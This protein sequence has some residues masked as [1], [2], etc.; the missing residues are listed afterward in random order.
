[1]KPGKFNEDIY[2]SEPLILIIIF[3]YEK[4]KKKNYK[5]KIS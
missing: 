3:E 5:K 1:M 2:M 4:V